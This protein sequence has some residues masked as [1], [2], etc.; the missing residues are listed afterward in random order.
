MSE[1]ITDLNIPIDINLPFL[2]K[3]S[4]YDLLS[5]T[6]LLNGNNKRI[7]N[8]FIIYRMTLHRELVSKG[9]KVSLTQL[10]TMAANAWKHETEE[11][12]KVYIDL[13]NDAKVLY[14]KIS[15]KEKNDTVLKNANNSN[16]MTDDFQLFDDQNLNVPHIAAQNDET[17]L[18]DSFNN[19]YS[20]NNLVTTENYN[21]GNKNSII[22]LV[23][24]LIGR[25]RVLEERQKLMAEL[26]GIQF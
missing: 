8:A 21:N 15:L 4:T 13:V 11:A 19:T 2:P 26:L 9:Y 5:R 7:P 10:S 17:L 16:N 20:F 6:T 12:K 3:I 23:N 25:I 1:S 18:L 22:S 14:R 24:E